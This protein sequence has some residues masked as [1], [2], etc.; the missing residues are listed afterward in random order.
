[1]S[2]K[3]MKEIIRFYGDVERHHA[4][5][6]YRR[7]YQKLTRL[8]SGESMMYFSRIEF[9]YYYLMWMD[10]IYLFSQLNKKPEH[11]KTK[12]AIHFSSSSCRFVTRTL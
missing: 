3:E 10:I 8:K 12:R 5:M 4:D 7:Y 9:I 6:A 11:V 1:M 2:K